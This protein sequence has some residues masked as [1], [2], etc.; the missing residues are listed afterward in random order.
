[1][2][3]NRRGFAESLRLFCMTRLAVIWLP[4]DQRCTDGGGPELERLLVYSV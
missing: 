3:G 4:Y 1:M 2:M